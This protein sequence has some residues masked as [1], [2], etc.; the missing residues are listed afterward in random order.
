M[1]VSNIHTMTVSTAPGHFETLT[2]DQEARLKDVWTHLLKFWGVPV[3]PAASVARSATSA[4]VASKA[5]K[6]SEHSEKSG[7]KKR[8][9]MFRKGHK[10]TKSTDHDGLS[11]TTTRTRESV[12]ETYNSKLIHD[13]L[14]D[15]EPQQIAD[16]FWNML[17]T[18][19]PDN[20]LLRFVR[21]R[22]WDVDKSLAMFAN[23]LHWRL[24]EAN[25]DQILWDGDRIP[26]ENK[27]DGF[28][29]QMQLNKA[30][31][32]GVDKAG[33]PIVVIRPRLHNA[34]KQTPKDLEKYTLL[35]IEIMRLA[36]QEPSDSASIIFDMT[37]FTMA[38]M[39]YGPV[40]FMIGIF[41]AHYPES[42]GKLFIHK[43]PWIFP[44][45]WSVV[46]NLLDPV[47]ASK[48]VF[49]KS[50][51]DLAEHV[52]TKYI[53][54]D[55]GGEDDYQPEWIEPNPED[56]KLL[57]DTETR[58]AIKAERAEIVKEYIEATVNWIEAKTAEESHKWKVEKRKV[59]VKLAE[60]YIK[61]DPYIRTK[62]NFDRAGCVNL[63][64][65]L[66]IDF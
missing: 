3:T 46:K 25:V 57:D 18:D 22:K 5:S 33:R 60:N 44:P 1:S 59:G 61:L 21:A 56:D 50:I 36:L 38:N 62:N 29:L 31:F 14:K 47:V 49:T 35:V 16:N 48:I 39:D 10:K 64:A 63:Q 8:F 52:D 26:F 11:L 23:T 13:A 32:R 7:K 34:K 9:G 40:N 17:R 58:D 27:E 15:L 51:K 41:E 43:A 2:A 4:S 28:I 54:A 30:Y 45:I 19:T 12:E 66:P 37:G 53:S 24:K 6:A 42:L 65:P 55:L 20:L